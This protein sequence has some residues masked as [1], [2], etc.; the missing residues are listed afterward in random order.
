MEAS[1]EIAPSESSATVP[2]WFYAFIPQR[3]SSGVTANLVPLFVVQVVGGT[4]ADVGRVTSLTALAGVP[5]SILWGNLSDRLGRRRPLLLLGFLGFA[6]STVLIGLGRS[7][8]EVMVISAVGGFLSMAVGP[9]GSALL[10]EE[11]PE[12]QWPE[13]LGRFNQIGGWSLVAGLLLG[14]V[15]LSVLS[16]WWSAGP[17]MRGL[18]ICAGAVAAVS[19][20]LAYRSVRE[21][22]AIR[23][24]RLF[25]PSLVGRL[26]VAVVERVLFFYPSRMLYFVLHPHSLTRVREEWS[27]TLSRYYVCSFLLFFAINVVFVPFPIF[28]TD[29]LGASNAQVFLVSVVKATMDALWYVPMGKLV[30]RRSGMELQAQAAAVRVG[31]FAVFGV[32]ALL[33]PGPMALIVVALAQA[34]S[35]ITWAAIAVSGTAAVATLTPKRLAGHAMGVYNAVIGGAGIVGSLAG[36]H[37]AESLGYGVSFGMGALLI[38]LTAVWLWRLRG[39]AEEGVGKGA[40][41]LDER[42]A[43]DDMTVGA[44]VREGLVV[45]STDQDGGEGSTQERQRG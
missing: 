31:V 24:R 5:A 12:D 15:W 9:V 11:V 32:L 43:G 29:V 40:A 39:S 30:H 36:G 18:L 13:S 20:I 16:R 2:A 17:V 35:G 10:L 42:G 41:W 26:G 38:G 4:V 44:Q 28:L 8:A 33:R 6:L 22:P 1:S 21:P 7:V 25:H 14:T 45:R 27:H 3:L 23:M 34:F 19:L 37:L